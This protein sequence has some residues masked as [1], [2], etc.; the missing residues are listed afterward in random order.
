MGAIISILK[1]KKPRPT[2]NENLQATQLMISRGV[3]LALG[4]LSYS[5]SPDIPKY[6][7]SS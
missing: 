1:M 3:L 7:S 2:I 6:L 5:K 4:F